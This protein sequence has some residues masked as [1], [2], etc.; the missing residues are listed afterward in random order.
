MHYSL[1][2]LFCPNLLKKKGIIKLVGIKVIWITTE[3][4]IKKIQNFKF[5]NSIIIGHRIR[6]GDS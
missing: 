3:T 2:T 5:S 6:W 4:L 1:E